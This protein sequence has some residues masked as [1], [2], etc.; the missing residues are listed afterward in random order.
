MVIVTNLRNIMRF[1][2][3][4]AFIVFSVAKAG[5]IHKWID[6]EGNLIRRG[7]LFVLRPYVELDDPRLPRR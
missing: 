5:D 1:L 3:Y 2:I 7:E 4:L 6:E